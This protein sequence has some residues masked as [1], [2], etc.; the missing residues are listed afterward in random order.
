MGL[1]RK[2]YPDLFDRKGNRIEKNVNP[3]PIER[4]LNRIEI[5]NRIRASDEGRGLGA[6][7]TVIEW[8]TTLNTFQENGKRDKAKL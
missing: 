2:R 7:T 6:S 1:I 8:F 5:E 3:N 4:Y